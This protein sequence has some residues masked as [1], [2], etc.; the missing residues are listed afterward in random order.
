M[1]RNPLQ[2]A[3]S[4]FTKTGA[5]T[6]EKTRPVLRAAITILLEQITP[7][8][9]LLRAYVVNIQSQC[10]DSPFQL[11]A[12]QLFAQQQNEMRILACW[13]GQFGLKMYRIT[14]RGVQGPTQAPRHRRT[15]AQIT[16]ELMQQTLTRKT[17]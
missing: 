11:Q 8:R 13:P 6:I 15:A 2:S 17:Q 1:I 10:T 5:Q 4:L 7:T 12:A 14:V 16:Y 3:H 9:L